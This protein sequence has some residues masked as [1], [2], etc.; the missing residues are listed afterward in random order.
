MHG[1]GFDLFSGACYF[2]R[3]FWNLVFSSENSENFEKIYI[4]I[5]DKLYFCILQGIYKL[6]HC[7]ELQN[8]VSQILT[9]KNHHVIL[10]K[11]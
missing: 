5:C 4:I 9:V 11:N 2:N 1:V 8:V 6:R 7:C 10:K 3:A